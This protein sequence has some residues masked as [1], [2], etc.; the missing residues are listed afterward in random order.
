[1]VVLAMSFLFLFSACSSVSIP[2]TT[3]PAL[4]PVPFEPLSVSQINI[5]IRINLKPL[6]ALAEKSIDTV[7]TST[8]YPNR[9]D[10][11]DCSIRYK[12]YFKRSPLK[13]AVNGSTLNLGFTG[14]YKIIG[15]TR[16]CAVGVV[17][18]PWT[19]ECKCGFDEGS[20]KVDIHFSSTF[21]LG[22]DYKLQIKI[23][24]AEP[25]PLNKCTICFWEQNITGAVMS[26]MKK[27]LDIS[28]KAIEDS[29]G[30]IDLKPY[31][32]KAWDKLNDVYMLPNLGYLSLK[33][34]QLMMENI[35][36]KNDLLNINLGITATPVI[37]FIR[38]NE[39]KVTV[40][41]ISELGTPGGFNINL[42]A[43]LQY[44]SLS[45][46]INTYLADKRFDFKEGFFKKYAVIKNCRV[47]SNLYDK[48]V[49]AVDFAGSHKG[50][51]YFT[52]KPVYDTASKK[53]VLDDF[54]Y[55]LT[56][57]DV[58]LKTAKWLFDQRIL[59]EIKKYTAFD[60]SGYYDTAATTINSW[61]NKEWTK[62]VRGSGKVAEVKLTGVYAQQ[63]HL[64]IRSNCTG[65]LSVEI[66]KINIPF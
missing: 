37:S 20:R 65:N 51:V 22:P 21:F 41:N 33:P 5:P 27:E 64:L 57:N 15:S 29:F 7:F 16:M 43:N 10:T 18:S 66:S 30:T 36:A 56:T 17:L 44:D 11:V 53:I 62:G 34:Q 48:I 58:M 26:A 35:N 24:R 60:L 49:V 39:E 6:Y 28:I 1:M 55:D 13:L 52:G 25:V 50:T 8:A 23:K 40:P 46:I 19:P 32:Q 14:S 12:Y 42:E 47:Y 45:K 3:P 2:R 54:A 61:L 63:Q 9:W 38:P 4:K 31:I 59:A